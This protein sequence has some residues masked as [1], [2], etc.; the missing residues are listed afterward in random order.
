MLGGQRAQITNQDNL[1]QTC[2]GLSLH[3]SSARGPLMS[4][5]A[6]IIAR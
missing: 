3:I 4:G 5:S 1:M 6:A 2:L